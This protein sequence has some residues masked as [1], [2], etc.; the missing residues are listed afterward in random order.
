[1]VDA[2][3]TPEVRILKCGCGD[4]ACS[5]YRLST[6]GSVGFSLADATLYAAAPDLLAVAREM[7]PPNLC[8]TNINIP[9]NTVVPID[10]HM[11]EL[12]RIAAAI[13]KA[14]ATHSTG[15]A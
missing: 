12:R 13:A 15:E 10:V 14:T 6:Q 1:M 9:D 5:Q 3:H 2:L 11:G 4:R 7:L 8:L